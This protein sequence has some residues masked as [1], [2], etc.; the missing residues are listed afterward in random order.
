M[1]V[2]DHTPRIGLSRFI[3]DE[4]LS[5]PEAHHYSPVVVRHTTPQNL[6]GRPASSFVG[7]AP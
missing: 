2:M 7:P 1:A 6:D 5:I 3:V 4:S